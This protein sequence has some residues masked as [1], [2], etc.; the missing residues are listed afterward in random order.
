MPPPIAYFSAMCLLPDDTDQRHAYVP[1]VQVGLLVRSIFRAP[2]ELRPS[3]LDVLS[4]DTEFNVSPISLFRGLSMAPMY[5][6]VRP[7]R[8]QN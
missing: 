2:L 7:H 3:L 4:T 8:R 6:T 5:A 1:D